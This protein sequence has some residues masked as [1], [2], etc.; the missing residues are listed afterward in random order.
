[1][2]GPNTFDRMV[3]RT[4]VTRP[5]SLHDEFKGAAKDC[6]KVINDVFRVFM[7]LIRRGR[8]VDKLR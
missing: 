6:I 5:Q 1:M 4:K 3:S 2:L 7:F 8:V